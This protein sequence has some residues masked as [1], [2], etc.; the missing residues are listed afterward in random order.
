MPEP[1]HEHIFPL[2][3]LEEEPGIWQKITSKVKGWFVK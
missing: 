1:V 2:A 3:E